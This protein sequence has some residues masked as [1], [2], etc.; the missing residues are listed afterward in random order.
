MRETP[1]AV[2]N[3]PNRTCNSRKP[4]KSTCSVAAQ[5]PASRRDSTARSL[6]AAGRISRFPQ[7]VLPPGQ[8][9]ALRYVPRRDGYSTTPCRGKARPRRP[10]GLTQ[11]ITLGLE[12]LGSPGASFSAGAWQDGW[13]GRSDLRLSAA[14]RGRQRSIALAACCVS[15][16]WG[17]AAHG[18]CSA[19]YG[20]RAAAGGTS[21]D[22]NAVRAAHRNS[23]ARPAHRGPAEAFRK[24]HHQ[25]Q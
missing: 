17:G 18:A 14:F 12:T 6:P 11:S 25:H 2:N 24:R 23:H 9:P 1:Q 21:C 4:D 8:G 13:Q 10:R 15:A 19:P 7:P 3:N 16:A 5:A 22:D 20:F